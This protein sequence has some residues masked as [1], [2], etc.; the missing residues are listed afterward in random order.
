MRNFKKGECARARVAQVAAVARRKKKGQRL[1]EELRRVA[2]DSPALDIILDDSG[3]RCPLT[4][5]KT[6]CFV[7]VLAAVVISKLRHLGR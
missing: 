4:G 3:R 6:P 5:E 1:H 7:R 2:Q